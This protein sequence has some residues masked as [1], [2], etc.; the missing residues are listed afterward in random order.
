MK[1]RTRVVLQLAALCF[2]LAAYG[3]ASD[4]GYLYIMNGIPGRDVAANLNPGFPVDVLINGLCQTRGLAFGSTDGPL[5]FSPGTYQVQISESNSLAPCTNTSIIDTPVTLTAGKSVSAVAAISTGQ[6]TLLQFSDSFTAVTA[7]NARFV[8]DHAADAGELLATLTQVGVAN[9]K[10]FTVTA[11]PGKEGTLT[12]PAGFY[13][14]QIAAD[15]STAVL[16]SETITLANRSATFTA[17]TG[18]AANSSVGLIY[19]TV[20]GVY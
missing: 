13:L 4:N 17:A 19:K 5:T 3:F 2:V 7:G 9:P 1:L 16:A 11:D 8:L 12:V 20:L 18:E 10:T 14:V 6:P 15:G